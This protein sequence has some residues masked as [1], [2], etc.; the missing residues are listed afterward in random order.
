MSQWC[1]LYAGRREA[2]AAALTERDEGSPVEQETFENVLHGGPSPADEWLLEGLTRLAAERLGRP[3]MDLD[4]EGGERLLSEDDAAE[5]G[6]AWVLPEAWM[7]LMADLPQADYRPLAA[8]L[9]KRL[10]LQTDD[11][12]VT[13][14][15]EQ[16]GR[17]VAICQSARN[18]QGVVVYTL[19]Y[20]KPT[21]T[22]WEGSGLR[23]GNSIDESGRQEVRNHPQVHL[24]TAQGPHVPPVLLPP[25]GRRGV[26]VP[27][28][29]GP[30]ASHRGL[31]DPAPRS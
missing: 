10:T 31:S 6:D 3:S 28:L 30:L 13:A 25:R 20:L 12:N 4:V 2:V 11:D 17:I 14:L 16:V 27:R 15:A 18:L 7:A 22:W 24:S 19:I 9:A 5:Y 29:G 21:P 23:E 8:A 1:D 26:L